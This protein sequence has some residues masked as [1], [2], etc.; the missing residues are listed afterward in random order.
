MAEKTDSVVRQPTIESERKSAQ[1]TT[2][3]PI[4]FKT[5]LLTLGAIGGAGL[6]LAGGTS[7]DE[8]S[9]KPMWITDPNDTTV[10]WFCGKH[11]A[12]NG[13]TFHQAIGEVL[14]E[15]PEFLFIHGHNL[16]QEFLKLQPTHPYTIRLGKRTTKFCDES[17][18]VVLDIDISPTLKCPTYK[19]RVELIT[20]KDTSKAIR[21]NGVYSIVQ[22]TTRSWIDANNAIANALGIRHQ[23]LNWLLAHECITHSPDWFGHVVS[24]PSPS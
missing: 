7:E 5:I 11:V 6:L 3:Q 19:L 15:D 22:E 10:Q 1:Q 12:R 20:F 18:I 8:T 16:K 9:A 21:I 13:R 24:P 23:Y 17:N 2:K 14:E 4:S